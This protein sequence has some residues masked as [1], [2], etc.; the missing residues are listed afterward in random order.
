MRAAKAGLVLVLVLVLQTALVADLP[1]FGVT[2]DAVILVPVAAGLT[3]GPERG[4]VAGFVAGLAFDLLVQT[5]FGLYAL[6]YCLVG[7]GV[8]AF[9]SGVLRAS[10]LLPIVAA[11]AGGA[12]GT[13]FWVLA[14]T[15]VGEEG[16]FDGE[17]LRILAVVAVVAGLLVL[18]ALRLA[19]WVEDEGDRPVLRPAR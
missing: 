4:A 14:A 16:L 17:L 18:P 12:L 2:A 3:V 19:R 9:Q 7:Y 5:P 10:R 11:M 13:G 6:A 1:I 8:G 15:V